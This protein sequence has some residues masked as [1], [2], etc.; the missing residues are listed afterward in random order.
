MKYSSVTMYYSRPGLTKDNIDNI[1]A[2]SGLDWV[3]GLTG[4]YYRDVHK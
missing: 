4:L 3:A 2:S 1:L